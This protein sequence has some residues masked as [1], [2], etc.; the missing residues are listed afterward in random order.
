MKNLYL[1]KTP[2]LVLAS[3]FLMAACSLIDGAKEIKDEL[4]ELDFTA[5]LSDLFP[6]LSYDEILS[7]SMDLSYDE[8]LDLKDEL[9]KARKAAAK[10]SEDLFVS[11]ESKIKERNTDLESLNGGYPETI[12]P[13]EASAFLSETTGDATILLNGIFRNR[14]GVQITNDNLTVTVDGVEQATQTSCLYSGDSVDIVF[15]LDITGS[16]SNVINSVKN[17][18]L[19]FVD[20]IESSG[21]NGTIAMVTYQD[22]VGVN[23]SFQEL[24]PEGVERSPFF[25]PVAIDNAQQVNEMRDFINR[26]EANNGMDLPENLSGAVD[27]ARNNT[28]GYSSNGNPNVIGEGS[29]DPEGTSPFPKLKSKHQIFVAFTDS[30]FHANSRD[31]NNSSL[32]KEFIPRSAEDIL[33]SLLQTGTVVNVSDPSWI[34]KTE[35]PTDSSDQVS[36]D[37]DYFAV[38]TGGIGED[39]I[40]GY[41]L[42]DLELVIT[43]ED[44]GLLDIT[45]DNILSS[46]C[47]VNIN[48]STS[49]TI[50]S[51]INLTLTETA[52]T[53][54]KKLSLK[55]F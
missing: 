29:D 47:Y 6:D 14:D 19:S 37:A 18:I 46:T 25:K 31:E 54:S 45:L 28:I 3:L 7:I 1:K 22:S 33:A 44:S 55:L 2:V 24:A 10:L 23:I 36:I 30:T 35:T 13:I 52:E 42:I 17:S 4:D 32:L 11:A 41:S 16:M 48:A 21:I 15:L 51:N 38:N 27:F 12:A 20:S 49:L 43:A 39:N 40:A 50:N 53:F 5:E 26:L 9:N 8:F 34:D